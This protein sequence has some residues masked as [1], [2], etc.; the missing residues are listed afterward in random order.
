MPMHTEKL[1]TAIDRGAGHDKVSIADP[2]AAPLGTDDEAAGTPIPPGA[3]NA[4]AQHEIRGSAR[5]IRDGHEPFFP[6]R[7]VLALAG[8][9]LLLACLAAYFG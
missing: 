9:M 8:L 1:R 7:T 4:A 6:T 2:A 3:V 5:P